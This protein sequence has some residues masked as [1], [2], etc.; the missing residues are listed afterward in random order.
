MERS[1]E[2]GAID[3]RTTIMQH[4]LRTVRTI[5]QSSMVCIYPLAYRPGLVRPDGQHVG[6]GNAEAERPGGS[7]GTHF[8]CTRCFLAMEM[9][10]SIHV[11]RQQAV[12]CSSPNVTDAFLSRDRRTRYG[13]GVSIVHTVVPTERADLSASHRIDPYPWSNVE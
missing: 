6:D 4:V 5:V 1:S 11:L 10:V 3:I 7:R 8:Y 9:L 13:Y 2:C 12:S